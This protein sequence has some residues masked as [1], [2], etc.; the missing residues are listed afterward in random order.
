MRFLPYR[1]IPQSEHQHNI[2]IFNDLK[3]TN[4]KNSIRYKNQAVTEYFIDKKRQN[5]NISLV[6][7]YNAAIYSSI[8][9]KH[10]NKTLTRTYLT[11][12]LPLI[13]KE[14]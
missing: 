1:E 4:N 8:K 2:L 12:I 7:S 9:Q 10:H 11:A 5:K 3:Y 13:Y 6:D 14:H